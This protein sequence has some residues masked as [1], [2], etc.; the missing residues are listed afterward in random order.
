MSL[1]PVFTLGTPMQGEKSDS[2]PADLL[3]KSLTK[4]YS[5]ITSFC[6]A[7][8]I[9]IYVTRIAISV[10]TIAIPLQDQYDLIITYTARGQMLLTDRL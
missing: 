7:A 1:E 6:R 8:L 4:P 5:R 2:N 9:V 10:R 3:D